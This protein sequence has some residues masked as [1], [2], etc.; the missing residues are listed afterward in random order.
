MVHAASS[1]L[2]DNEAVAAAI[3]RKRDLTLL[4]IK[5]NYVVYL[6]LHSLHHYLLCC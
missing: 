3:R 4:L 2:K 1:Y 6:L 5:V